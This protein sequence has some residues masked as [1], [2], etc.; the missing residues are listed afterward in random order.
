MIASYRQH[1]YYKEAL[2]LYEQMIEEGTNK[3][4]VFGVKDGCHPQTQEIYATLEK[5]SQ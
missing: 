4:H 3:V 1:G 2:H 5:L